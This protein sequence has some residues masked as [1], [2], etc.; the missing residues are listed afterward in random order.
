MSHTEIEAPSTAGSAPSTGGN[1]A[2]APFPA[3]RSWWARLFRRGRPAA[4]APS[5]PAGSASAPPASAGPPAVSDGPVTTNGNATTNGLSAHNGAGKVRSHVTTIPA[6]ASP[7]ESTGGGAGACEH[8]V[9]SDEVAATPG[10]PVEPVASGPPPH[11]GPGAAALSLSGRVTTRAGKALAGATVS[12]LGLDG[13]GAGRAT[14]NREGRYQVAALPGGVYAVTAQLAPHRPVAMLLS[15]SS[16]QAVLDL[17][18]TG[19]GVLTGRVVTGLDR[20]VLADVPIRLVGADGRTA[21]TVFSDA[22]GT[23]RFTEVDE[24]EWGVAVQSPRYREATVAASVSADAETVVD[25]VL[26]GNGS[27]AGQVTAPGG[28]PVP[29]SRVLLLDS[30]GEVRASTLTDPSGAYG[31]SEIPTGGYAVVVVDL[32]PAAGAVRVTASEAATCDLRVRDQAPA[33]GPEATTV[34]PALGP[35]ASR[36][37]GPTSGT[38]S[39]PVGSPPPAA[40]VPPSDLPPLVPPPEGGVAAPVP[41]ASGGLP[42]SATKG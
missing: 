30:N 18:L 19:R 40:A 25:V 16:G 12:V 28:T 17:A 13:R 3:R 39:P 24:G 11:P 35:D 22:D 23:Y 38:T 20:M 41:A 8:G 14:T 6:T 27:V 4:V 7:L 36:P 42:A 29:G 26:E 5:V 10:T 37:I 32:T 9:M 1:A 33:A 15:L 34:G 21:A 2:T 31:F